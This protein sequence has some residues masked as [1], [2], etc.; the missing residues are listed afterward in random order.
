ME[1]LS[2]HPDKTADIQNMFKNMDIDMSG[3]HYSS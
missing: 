3:K 1:M 2:N